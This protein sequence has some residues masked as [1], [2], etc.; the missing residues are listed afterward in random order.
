M[1]VAFGYRKMHDCLLESLWQ[2][3]IFYLNDAYK[4]GEIY[5]K[6]VY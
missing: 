5:S 2:L 6:K 1:S 3:F 4:T